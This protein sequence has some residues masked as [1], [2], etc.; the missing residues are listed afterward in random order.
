MEVGKKM[1]KLKS[2]EEK[3]FSQRK[4]KAGIFAR[5]WKS[6]I[7]GKIWAILPDFLRVLEESRLENIAGS[8]RHA[9][10]APAT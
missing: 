8:Y 6:R 10:I 1:D 4:G 3:H 5:A 7:F 2:E 9:T